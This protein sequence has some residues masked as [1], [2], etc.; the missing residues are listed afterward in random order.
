MFVT[1]PYCN[2]TH[3]FFSAAIGTGLTQR[4]LYAVMSNLLFKLFFNVSLSEELCI[5][6]DKFN[7][8][9]VNTIPTIL[10]SFALSL[11]T[12]IEIMSKSSQGLHS[13]SVSGRYNWFVHVNMALFNIA[14]LLSIT[15]SLTYY[16]KAYHAKF[17]DDSRLFA[18]F[19]AYCCCIQD[20]YLIFFTLSFCTLLLIKILTGKCDNNSFSSYKSLYCNQS[21]NSNE[22]PSPLLLILVLSPHAY[23]C[24]F[25]GTRFSAILS[26]YVI[27]VITIF[28]TF[29]YMNIWANYPQF[30]LYYIAGCYLMIYEAERQRLQLF[31][32]NRDL[33]INLVE[34]QRLEKETRT[35]EM[36][37]MI[38]NL[39][40]TI[41]DVSACFYCSR[42]N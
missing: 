6:Y 40:S 38:Y 23:P 14:F 35:S 19:K 9:K 28:Y 11:F 20:M 15:I 5:E 39:G 17:L 7:D 36:R 32:S 31:L 3:F 4:Y 8:Q 33:Q 41:K 12:Y 25:T 26:S 2:L 37:Y 42:D 34:N 16:L 22:I 21:Y 13:H 27:S 30:V 1:V 29:T 18:R 24:L 10:C